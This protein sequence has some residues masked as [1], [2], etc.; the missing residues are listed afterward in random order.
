MKLQRMM[1]NAK[2]IETEAKNEIFIKAAALYNSISEDDVIAQLG[3]GNEIQ[4]GTDWYEFIRDIESITL[5]RSARVSQ[6]VK[7]KLCDC[8]HTIQSS[9]VMTTSTGTSCP[10]C[11]DKISE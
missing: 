10:E 4:Y 2:W 5:K 7:M 8:G 3:D 1:S 6:P 9:Q 11:Y